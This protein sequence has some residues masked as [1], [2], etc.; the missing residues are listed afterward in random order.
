M[1]GFYRMLHT[2]RDAK[3]AIVTSYAEAANTRENDWGNYRGDRSKE[4]SLICGTYG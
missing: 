4:A 1:L 3:E 2:G